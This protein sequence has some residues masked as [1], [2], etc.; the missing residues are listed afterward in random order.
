MT[1][2]VL[3]K[4]SRGADRWSSVSLLRIFHFYSLTNRVCE[5]SGHDSLEE[6]RRRMDKNERI[7]GLFWET[8]DSGSSRGRGSRDSHRICTTLIERR[9]GG[10]TDNRV[11]TH[12]SP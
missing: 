3:P 12:R 4:C 11:P 10:R 1:I 7:G 9:K 5:E 2:L 8:I 6:P